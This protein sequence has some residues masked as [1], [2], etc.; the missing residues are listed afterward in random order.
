MLLCVKSRRTSFM[1]QGEWGRDSLSVRRLIS[2]HSQCSLFNLNWPVHSSQ[3]MRKWVWTWPENTCRHVITSTE[4]ERMC[5]EQ[6]GSH[7]HRTRIHRC[8]WWCCVMLNRARSTSWRE[9]VGGREMT[10]KRKRKRE[11]EKERGGKDIQV[12]TEI[13][14]TGRWCQRQRKPHLCTE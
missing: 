3:W 14:Q 1:H 2:T 8:N 7:F 11:G 10:G 12:M 6:C 13:T 5:S 4:R 9:T